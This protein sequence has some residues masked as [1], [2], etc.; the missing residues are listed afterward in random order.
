MT[1][2]HSQ[3]ITMTLYDNETY[4]DDKEEREASEDAS[5]P[6]VTTSKR[7]DGSARSFQTMKDLED[8]LSANGIST[9]DYKSSKRLTCGIFVI[10][11]GV[12]PF[13]ISRRS[14]S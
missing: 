3:I 4:N 2:S 13:L 9:S 8:H 1:N 11:Q 14:H 5:I 7:D 12:L 6:T 10:I